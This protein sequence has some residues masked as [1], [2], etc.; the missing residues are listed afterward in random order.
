MIN[1]DERFWVGSRLDNGVEQTT[2]VFDWDQRRQYKVTGPAKSLLDEDDSEIEVLKKFVDQL[3]PAVHTIVVDEQDSVVSLSSDPEKDPTFALRYP[4]LFDAP[5]LQDCR[6]IQLPRLRELDRLGPGVDLMSY[7]NESGVT[8]K[9]IFKYNMIVQRI[10]KTW[11]ELCLLKSVRHDHPNIVHL[12]RIVIDDIESMILGFTIPYISGGTFE[13]NKTR[14]FRLE[15]LQ[16]LTAVVDYLNLQKG[17]AHQDIAPRNLLIK[18]DPEHPEHDA[19]QLFDFDFAGQIDGRGFCP[20]RDDVSGV[21]FTLYEIVTHDGSLREVMFE[22][23]DAQKVL[24]LSEWPVKCCLD[25]DIM[26][27]R[28]HLV[29]WVRRRRETEVTMDS[30][31]RGAPPIIPDM[32]SPRPVIVDIDES[33]KPVYDSGIIQSRTKA[34]KMGQHVVKWERPPYYK[35]YPQS[36][37]NGHSLCHT[38]G[39]SMAEGCN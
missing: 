7:S 18:S 1:P 11:D 35:A 24:D 39:T 6:T 17:I 38:I 3:D 22:E 20:E 4:N 36:H 23:Q 28:Q 29:E 26:T 9:V 27:F 5:L 31:I 19:L 15:W 12:D 30:K 37:G 33:G 14:T 16:Q 34:L 2:T 8:K 32:P 25:A 21:I 10:E 13:D